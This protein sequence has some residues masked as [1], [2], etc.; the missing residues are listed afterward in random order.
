MLKNALFFWKKLEKSP[1]R[2]GLCPQTLVGLRL[3]PLGPLV[4]IHIQFTCYF[5]ALRRFLSIVKI[6]ITTYY[7]VLEWR[8]VGPLAKLASLAQPLV[9]Q[10]EVGALVQ[11]KVGCRS[12]VK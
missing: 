8:L 1:Q 4:V 9:T 12:L 7:L 11:A 3:L 6:K 10:L 5:W 2:W